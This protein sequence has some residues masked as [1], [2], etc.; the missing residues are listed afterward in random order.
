MFMREECRPAYQNGVHFVETLTQ[1][2]KKCHNLYKYSRDVLASV[3]LMLEPCLRSV[4][5]RAA[6]GTYCR[7]HKYI[8]GHLHEISCTYF[9]FFYYDEPRPLEREGNSQK[10][11]TIPLHAS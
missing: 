3:R 1:A 8:R 2:R 10:L 11:A 5:Y 6:C 9:R 7:I 4:H